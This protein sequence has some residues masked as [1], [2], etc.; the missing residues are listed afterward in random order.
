MSLVSIGAQDWPTL[1]VV[2]ADGTAGAATLRQ[3]DVVAALRY[4]QARGAKV[5][6][7]QH[8]PGRGMAGLHAFLLAQVRAACCLFVTPDLIL[9]PGLIGR[10]HAMLA[11]QGCGFVGSAAHCLQD[12]VSLCHVR[13]CRCHRMHPT[14]ACRVAWVD[15]CVLFDTAKLRAAGGFDMPSTQPLEHPDAHAS[16]QA[17][18]KVD[19]IEIEIATAEAQRRVMR[20]YGGCGL[21]PSGAYRIEAP[22][23]QGEQQGQPTADANAAHA[24]NAAVDTVDAAKA[25]AALDAVKAHTA[26]DSGGQ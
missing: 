14:R 8:R 25:H 26:L 22:G 11:E 12:G 17:G 10:L 20:A 19:A 23:R 9:E 7:W 15:G 16:V 5:N 24:A 3:P 21:T 2:V 6:T 1:R 18:I 4:L 13:S